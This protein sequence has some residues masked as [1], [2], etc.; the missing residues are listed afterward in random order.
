MAS[1][2]VALWLL[3]FLNREIRTATMSQSAPKLKSYETSGVLAGIAAFVTWGLIPGYWK[4]MRAVPATEI[5]AHR[6][7]WT[8]LFLTALLTWQQRW[9]EVGS[10]DAYC[11]RPDFGGT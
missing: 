5:L 9:A 2:L 3:S 1:T 8:M 10:M 4:L 7:V 11:A 6:Y